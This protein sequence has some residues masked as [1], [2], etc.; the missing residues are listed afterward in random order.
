MKENDK[1]FKVIPSFGSLFT[2]A[3]RATE[4][5][6]GIVTNGLLNYLEDQ[7]VLTVGPECPSW[8][9][10]DD[11]VHLDVSH[12]AKKKYES[13]CLAKDINGQQVLEYTFPTENI[14]GVD[15]MI[16]NPRDILYVT[17]INE[18]HYQNKD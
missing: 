2:T 3:I 7:R 13:D 9:K 5:K 8:I 4:T 16:I 11:I 14:G 15:I 12:F 1:K 6:S 10:E 18:A 17:Q